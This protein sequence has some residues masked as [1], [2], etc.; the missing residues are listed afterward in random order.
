M[1]VFATLTE[2]SPR[3]A[4]WFKVFGSDRIRLVDSR[5]DLVLLPGFDGPRRCW[6]FDLGDSTVTASW[7]V[8][9][10]FVA[11]QFCNGDQVAGARLVADQDFVPILDGPDLRVTVEAGFYL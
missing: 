4:A 9:E 7:R 10:E 11:G 2:D 3:Q 8:L 6:W 1:P 5:S